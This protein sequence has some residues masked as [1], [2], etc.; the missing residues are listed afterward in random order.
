VFAVLPLRIPC[1]MLKCDDKLIALL[2]F[3]QLV[4]FYKV[5]YSHQPTYKEQRTQNF[6]IEGGQLNTKYRGDLC[7]ITLLVGVKGI[8]GV[9]EWGN[10]PLPQEKNKVFAVLH[11]DAF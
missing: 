8:E 2:R 1:F 3:N 10:S 4:K 5:K 6:V 11:S 7:S 9:E